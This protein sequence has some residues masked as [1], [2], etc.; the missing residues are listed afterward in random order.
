M[1]E[2]TNEVIFAEG[3]QVFD[4]VLHAP[5]GPVD[6]ISVRFVSEDGFTEIAFT[7]GDAIQLSELVADMVAKAGRRRGDEEVSDGFGSTWLRCGPQCTLE[8]VRP[9]KVQCNGG[10]DCPNG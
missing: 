4:V 3:F 8:V 6:G 1:N 9:G 2:D 5:E 10:P 7:E